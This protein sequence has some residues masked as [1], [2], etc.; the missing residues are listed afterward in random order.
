MLTPLE[1]V[2]LRSVLD[3]LQTICTFSLPTV[4]SY[5]RMVDGV[6]SDGKYVSWGTENREAPVRL[7]GAPDLIDL[8][9]D[10]WTGWQV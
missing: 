10:A 9:Y 4:A 7:C 2:F 5:A 3:N 6:W 8:R 1:S